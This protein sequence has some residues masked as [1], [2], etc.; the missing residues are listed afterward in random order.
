MGR[1]D[2]MSRGRSGGGVRLRPVFG[3]RG[4]GGG[5]LLMGAGASGA[6]V[7]VLEAVGCGRLFFFAPRC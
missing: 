5:V 7:L 3:I 6:P 1:A 2:P 4:E